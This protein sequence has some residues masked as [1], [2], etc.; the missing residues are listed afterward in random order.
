MTTSTDGIICYGIMFEEEY[1]FPWDTDEEAEGDIE[2]WWRKQVGWK[3]TKEVYDSAGERL[4]GVTEGEIRAYFE[5]QRTF[6]AL[7][8]VPIVTVNYCSGDCEMIILAVPSTV[9]RCFR[10]EAL[11]FSPS[12]LIVSDEQR[13]ALIDFCA[14][15]GI[16]AAGNPS[17]YLASYWG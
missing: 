3:V 15:H 7:H 13:A 12:D 16:E 9:R 5:Q 8:P 11:A 2:D 1:L 17:W 4:P 6:D 10:G 14:K